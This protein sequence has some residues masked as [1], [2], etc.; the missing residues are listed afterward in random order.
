M[1]KWLNEWVLLTRL[2]IHEC[3]PK[4][5]DTWTVGQFFGKKSGYGEVMTLLKAIEKKMSSLPSSSLLRSK[6]MSPLGRFKGHW[7]MYYW[8]MLSQLK[9]IIWGQNMSRCIF[10]WQHLNNSF[11]AMS[12]LG[13]WFYELF[14]EIYLIIL[15]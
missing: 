13:L 10:K 5:D 6:G 2:G 8:H 11:Q 3:L 1:N 15:F 7:K 4:R 9:I 14:G 12:F